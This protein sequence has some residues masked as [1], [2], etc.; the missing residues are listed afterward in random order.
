[1]K[2]IPQVNRD[3]LSALFT[4]LHIIHLNRATNF[5]TA[6]N[7]SAVFAPL[8]FRNHSTPFTTENHRKANSLLTKVILKV[9]EL[10]HLIQEPATDSIYAS[11]GNA[12]V[13]YVDLCK[14]LLEPSLSIVT[15]L[16][17]IVEV[18][19]LEQT[20]K[21]LA[22]CFYKNKQHVSLLKKVIRNEVQATVDS[23]TLFRTNSIATHLLT[24]LSRTLG[25]KYLR[26]LLYP[27]VK[28]LT[29]I[30]DLDTFELNTGTPA[31]LEENRKFILEQTNKFFDAIINSVDECPTALRGILGI[32]QEEVLEKFPASRYISVGGFYFLRFACPAI[33]SPEG[34]G[35]ISAV[36]PEVRKGLVVISK[37][38]QNISNGTV[39]KEPNMSFVNDF[40]QSSIPKCRE[41]LDKIA[42]CK[43]SPSP[44]PDEIKV[45][46]AALARIHYQL[47]EKLMEIDE[48]LAMDPANAHLRKDLMETL[49]KL[50][51]PPPKEILE[52]RDRFPILAARI[53]G[54]QKS[55]Q[56][57]TV[58]SDGK[59]VWSADL[60]GVIRGW[61]A[62]T[63]ELSGEI[64]SNLHNI[65]AI[66]SVQSQMWVSAECL[67][68]Y[69]CLTGK[70]IKTITS[71]PTFSFVVVG[72]KVWCAGQQS[73]Q[74]YDPKRLDSIHSI[75]TQGKMFFT[76]AHI[77]NTV[78]GGTNQS[79]IVIWNASNYKQIKDIK[80]GHTG[81]IN[82][83]VRV[84]ATS[85]IWSS[86][87]DSKI[88]VWDANTYELLKTFNSHRGKIFNLCDF[89]N[90]V[91]SLSWDNSI[92]IWHATSLTHVGELST[93]HTDAINSVVPAWN[94]LLSEWVAWTGSLDRSVCVW[95]VQGCNLPAP[96]E[97]EASSSSSSKSSKKTKK[98]EKGSS[99]S[100][101]SK[102]GLK[103]SGKKKS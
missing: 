12:T 13:S 73:I 17:R 84:A 34:F 20:A 36:S 63:G 58:S 100:T 75:S 96:T 92:Q 64:L 28:N 99:Q 4:L 77:G 51:V 6:E 68:V 31:K 46:H 93:G 23:G 101:S 47:N 15:C 59:T 21:D 50:G 40:I 83:A 81:K 14:I 74:I 98:L 26:Q 30:K 89:G 37:T 18:T 56:T 27:L 38:I 52:L 11:S 69:D 41:F 79:S 22:F 67:A 44:L 102:D 7:L 103:S 42:D 10:F 19:Q 5:M 33:V 29:L 90:Q 43:I 76:L 57:I 53:V 80:E 62:D 66:A 78:W 49:S 35:V 95:R 60:N 97:E 2:A 65:F 87:D 32:L 16:G 71:E 55:I 45:K 3:L 88:C 54:H 86:A 1:M 48:K 91:W 72:D 85:T 94:S 61:N 39:N 24:Q 8:L 82:A 25:L 70:L 9:D